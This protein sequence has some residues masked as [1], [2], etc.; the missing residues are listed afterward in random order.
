METCLLNDFLES[1]KPWLSE[2]YIHSA[3]LD[4]NGHM[5]LLFKD[6][7]QNVYSIDDCTKEQLIDILKDLQGKG[8]KVQT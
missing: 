6:N 2:E 5:V 7:V 4:E 3:Y 1:L 8:V